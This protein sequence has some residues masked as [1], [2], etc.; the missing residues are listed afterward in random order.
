MDSSLDTLLVEYDRL[1]TEREEFL[2]AHSALWARYGPGGTAALLRSRKEARL[3]QEIRELNPRWTERR[4]EDSVAASES[5][6]ATLK[7]METGR[8]EYHEQKARLDVSARRLA[9]LSARIR[10]AGAAI[11][12]IEDS[13]VTSASTDDGYDAA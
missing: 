9:L 12:E 2:T 6:G 5:W 7:A 1:L 10:L 13:G 4:L 11:V 3:K 8:H